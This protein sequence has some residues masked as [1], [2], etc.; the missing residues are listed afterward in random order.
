MIHE[1]DV[2]IIKS[3]DYQG[4][5]AMIFSVLSSEERTKANSFVYEHLRRRYVLARGILRLLISRYIDISPETICFDYTFYGKPFC[6][7]APD[8]HFNMS[9]S[10]DGLAYI[11]SFNHEVGIDIELINEDLS[12]ESL[13]LQVMSPTERQEFHKLKDAQRLEFF[14]D[15]WTL[16]ES[17]LK[18]V[19]IGLS[20][21]LPNL[22][23]L[24]DLPAGPKIQLSAGSQPSLFDF[25]TWT[26]TFKPLPHYSGALS[27]HEKRPIQDSVLD[28]SSFFES[29]SFPFANLSP[30]LAAL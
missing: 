1:K 7:N 11:F 21:P 13:I 16:K 26:F 14:Y 24:R 10:G 9:H 8:F 6:K 23:I 20:Y 4:D 25:K 19:S 12:L 18:A 30:S 15:T 17:F 22:T 3:D 29:Y 2:Y 27:I 28:C 5:I